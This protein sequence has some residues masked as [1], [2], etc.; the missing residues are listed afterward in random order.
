MAGDN[1]SGHGCHSTSIYIH[2]Y[3]HSPFLS[4]IAVRSRE[5]ECGVY[6]GVRLDERD[7]R[8]INGDGVW[9]KQEEKQRKVVLRNN[10][11]SMV[12]GPVYT[13]GAHQ[14]CHT[15]VTPYSHIGRICSS[16]LHLYMRGV[17]LDFTATYMPNASSLA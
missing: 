7:V 16:E 2:I 15:S 11:G 1:G 13:G 9:V 6:G 17:W 4:L 10:L 5:W 14:T 3:F 12:D 8:G